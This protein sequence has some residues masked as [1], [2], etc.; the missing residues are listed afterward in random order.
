MRR[1]A[2]AAAS[3]AAAAAAAAAFA[4]PVAAQDDASGL[5]TAPDATS[6]APS[7]QPTVTTPEAGAPPIAPAGGASDLG[8]FQ[9][10]VDK[11][12]P[13]AAN[14]SGPRA[15]HRAASKDTTT[16]TTTDASTAADAAALF[17]LDGQL[18]APPTIGVPNVL[19]DS[20]SIPPFLLPIYQ[21]A[22]IEYGVRWEVLAAI[23]AVETNYGRN[24]SIST[25]GAVGWMQFMPSTWA[26]YG[27]DANGD[28]ERDP[29][30]PV[31]A[32]F[33]AARYL[34]A[35]GAGTNLKAAI[36]SY[37]HLASYVD[38]VIARAQAL[39]A[40]PSDVIGSLTGL[41]SGRFP[42]TGA[43]SYADAYVPA[44]P[45][46]TSASI[47]VAGRAGRRTVDVYARSGA[48]AIAV[49][50]GQVVRIGQ[51]KRLG[52]F[53]Q[54]RDAYGNTY[55]YG[56]LAAVS[57]MHA[58]PRTTT[59]GAAESAPAAAAPTPAAPTGAGTQT[60]AAG[61]KAAAARRT[62]PRPVKERLF[63]EPQRPRAFHAGGE[64]QLSQVAPT[65][66]ATIADGDLGQYFAPPYDLRRDEVVLE[67]LRQGSHVVAGTILGRIGDASLAY[68][69]GGAPAATAAR[70]LGTSTV[71]HLRFEIRP[72]GDGA[73]RIDPGP[74]LDGWKLLATSNVYGSQNPLLRGTGTTG[75]IG[76]ILLESKEALEQRVLN[77]PA[78]DI[79]A[80]GRQ[81]IAAGIIDRRV[82]AT[83]EY[84]AASGLKPTVS[85]LRCGHGFYTSSGNVSEHSSGNAV[86]I[87][88]IN[89][90]P[91][92]GH[93]GEGSI[94]DI[95][96]RRLLELQGALKPHQIITL[97]QYANTDNT[98][99]MA[100]HND[101]I[102]VGFQPL[103]GTN[104]AAG[105]ALN[106]VLAP[107]DWTRLSSRLAAIGNP[108][109]PTAP[110]RFSLKVKVSIPSK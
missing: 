92:L 41:T 33:A 96:V 51:S 74:V 99:A 108:T 75:S 91:I 11:R 76:Q 85:T 9:V 94:T 30:N 23:N 27:V 18:L 43:T 5:T 29:Y 19:I 2:Q 57:A 101:H 10:Q 62:A 64:R 52:R 69:R 12:P 97:M 67:P 50:D 98:F 60:A 35:S 70:R 53:V 109:V 68:D 48:A 107:K 16:Q 13:A 78:I 17:G 66:R 58:V 8:T 93:Q 39:A 87:G 54:L 90:T 38:D 110:S 44:K 40:L 106:A 82:L 22:G 84:L 63:A 80:C 34:H 7:E 15:K 79:Y 6:A 72:A 1:R 61:P 95:T 77:D 56:H 103:Y 83:L 31:D 32:I 4:G 81:D 71:P 102:H 3:V 36:F 104:D 105:K 47:A 89:G 42:V 100:D 55:T 86:D 37:N 24:L 28:G 65:Q 25:A 14:R 21:A 20:L 46:G 59:G 88:A 49:Q 73:P 26:T 45:T